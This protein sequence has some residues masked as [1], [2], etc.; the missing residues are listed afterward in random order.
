[1]LNHTIDL[2][3]SMEHQNPRTLYFLPHQSRR[4]SHCATKSE[5][6]LKIG[7]P[8]SSQILSVRSDYRVAQSVLRVDIPTFG[9]RLSAKIRSFYSAT[10]MTFRSPRKRVVASI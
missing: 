4:T 5:T 1:M 3:V 8:N 9:L 7:V 2:F 6:Q 10:T